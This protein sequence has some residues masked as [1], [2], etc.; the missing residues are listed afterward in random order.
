M[1]YDT[2][3][4]GERWDEILEEITRDLADEPSPSSQAE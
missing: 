4:F 2:S 3:I 1:D